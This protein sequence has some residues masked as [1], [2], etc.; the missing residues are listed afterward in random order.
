MRKRKDPLTPLKNFDYKIIGERVWG[1]LLN[2][3]RDLRKSQE[4]ADPELLENYAHLL[5]I[6]VRCSMNSY[7]AVLYFAG[8]IPEDPRRK[9]NFRHRGASNKPP[10][11]RSPIHGCVSVR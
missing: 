4:I 10:T 9:R 11:S 1:L 3:D 6:F 2:V 8:D 7:E 5:D